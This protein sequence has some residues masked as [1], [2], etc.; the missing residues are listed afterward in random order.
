MGG[1]GA[2]PVPNV[3]ALAS[4]LMVQRGGDW[5]SSSPPI[6]LLAVSNVPN[7]TALASHL[8]VQ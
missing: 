2:H 3:T 8:M 1:A 4:H 5:V 7:V 6:P